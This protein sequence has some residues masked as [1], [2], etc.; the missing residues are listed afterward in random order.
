[1][2]QTK[3]TKCQSKHKVVSIGTFDINGDGVPELVTGYS[4]GKLDARTYSTGEVIF[5]ILL[6]SGVAGLVEADYRRTGKSDLVVVSTNGEGAKRTIILIT[7]LSAITPLPGILIR[8]AF[9]AVRGYSAGSAMQTPE[10]GEVIRELLARKQ[11]LQ[12]ELRQRAA[13]STSMYYGSRLAVSLMTNRRAARVAFA[14]GPGLLVT[15]N[16]SRLLDLIFNRSIHRIM[17]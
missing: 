7:K 4:S 13:T 14:A 6:S 16:I 17:K 3:F 9:H 8:V 2:M 11:A 15:R 10:P 5:K 1:M 12:M